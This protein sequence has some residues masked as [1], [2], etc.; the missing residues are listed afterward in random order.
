MS[1]T[2]RSRGAGAMAVILTVYETAPEGLV[3]SQRH[4]LT[5][6]DVCVDPTWVN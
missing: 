6:A 2:M 1:K 4:A 3:S 5:P